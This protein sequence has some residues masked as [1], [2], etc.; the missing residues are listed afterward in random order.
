MKIKNNMMAFIVITIIFSG[1]GIAKYMNLWKTESSKVPAKYN[2]G[3]YAGQYNPNDIRGSYSFSDINKAF[4]I[5]INLLAQ[6]FGVENV[7]N[8]SDFKV[9][10]FENIYASL[11]DEGKEIGTSSVKLFVALYKGLPYELSEDTYLPNKAVDILKSEA[12]LTKEQIG[13]IE[14]HSAQVKANLSNNN[15]NR[16]EAEE[17]EEQI[18]KGKTTFKEVIQWGVS[19]EHIEKILGNKIGNKAVTIRDYCAENNIEFS[20]IKEEI[21]NQIDELKK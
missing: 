16:E 17:S 20:K 3:E 13:Y 19:Q 14:K 6:A 8:I 18:V 11:K 4:D 12:K 15:V 2:T 7:D 10:D 21:Q 1:I 5:D 9:K